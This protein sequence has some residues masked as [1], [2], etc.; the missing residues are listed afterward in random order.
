MNAKQVNRKRRNGSPRGSV[1]FWEKLLV[2]LKDKLLRL[3]AICYG[4]GEVAHNFFQDN[5]QSLMAA[6]PFWV[7][8]VVLIILGGVYS[9]PRKIE[10]VRASDNTSRKVV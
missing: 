6:A 1:Y 3:G 5:K 4:L 7:A 2:C 8:A 10:E 9:S